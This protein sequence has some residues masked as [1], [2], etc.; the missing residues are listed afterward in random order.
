M[1][2]MLR[3]EMILRINQLKL[4]QNIEIKIKNDEKFKKYK[5]TIYYININYI[6]E[7]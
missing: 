1:R 7:K 3:L 6:N 2:L 5:L 4:R